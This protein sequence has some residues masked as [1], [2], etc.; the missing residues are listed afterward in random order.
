MNKDV[1]N[2]I[3]NESK[4]SVRAFQ[5]IN[6]D[7]YFLISSP[8][9]EKKEDN[10]DVINIYNKCANKI[11][12]VQY[13]II[14]EGNY[15]IAFLYNIYVDKEYYKKGVGT[16][17]LNFFEEVITSKCCNSVEGKFYPKKP[18]NKEQVEKFYIKNGYSI[19]IEGYQQM[20][21]KYISKENIDLVKNNTFTKKGL[22]VYGDLNN[23]YKSN[24][25]EK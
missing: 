9:F 3:K 25:L 21:F 6:K 20:I 11:G 16:Y 24:E 5:D 18:A 2:L 23:F 19:D 1:I 13:S 14:K 10:Y 22:K 7:K 8:S 4:E 15:N 12:H 17:A